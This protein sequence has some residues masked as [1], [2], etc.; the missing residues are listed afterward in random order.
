MSPPPRN[1][2]IV[3]KWA[4]DLIFLMGLF[5]SL[6]LALALSSVSAL[7]GLQVNTF[8]LLGIFWMLSGGLALHALLRGPGGGR[9]WLSRCMTACAL[10]L[11]GLGIA[12]AVVV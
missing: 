10:L 12:V 11:G 2:R 3:P 8:G 9:L 7:V 4:A 5:A 6:P 1:E